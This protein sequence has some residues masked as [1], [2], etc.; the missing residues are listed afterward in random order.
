MFQIFKCKQYNLEKKPQYHK[1]SRL[2]KTHFLSKVHKNLFDVSGKLL[3]ANCV[4]HAKN[5]AFRSP[6]ETAVK[7]KGQS[8]IKDTEDFVDK[9]K[10]INA[11]P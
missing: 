3:I 5:I 2:D 11:I 7:K 6:F 10:N 4:I 1:A 8:Y 9:I